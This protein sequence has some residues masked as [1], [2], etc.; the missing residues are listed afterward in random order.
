MDNYESRLAEFRAEARRV[1]DDQMRIMRIDERTNE[2]I[3]RT[4]KTI[5]N[6]HE[7]QLLIDDARK[8]D[9]DVRQMQLIALHMAIG[10][11]PYVRVMLI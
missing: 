8:F 1:Y 11:G 9:E 6:S 2:L 7:F 4:R 10:K 3:E 5:T